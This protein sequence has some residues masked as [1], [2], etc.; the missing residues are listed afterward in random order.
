VQFRILGSLEITGP[1]G[2][3]VLESAKVRSV[4]ALLLTHAGEVVSAE[5]LIDDLW[6]GTP[7]RS[8]GATLQTYI[9]QLR[10]HLGAAVVKSAPGGYRIGLDDHWLD[11]AEFEAT[12]DDIAQSRGDDPSMTRPGCPTRAPG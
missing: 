4:L 9:S 3:V 5:R 7:P 6:E 11:A 1:D 12:L 2:P 10:K 8:A